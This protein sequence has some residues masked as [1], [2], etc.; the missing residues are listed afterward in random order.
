MSKLETNHREQCVL[1]T[2]TSVIILYQDFFLIIEG[3]FSLK[4]TKSTFQHF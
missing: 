2:P 4:K 1:I 3:F